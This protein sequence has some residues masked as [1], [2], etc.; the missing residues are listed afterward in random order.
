MFFGQT[1]FRDFCLTFPVFFFF[2]FTARKRSCG[3][4][5]F[6][7]LPTSHS[8]HRLGVYPSMYPG[9]GC[10]S[11]HVPGQGEGVDR[12]CVNGGVDGDKSTVWTGGVHPP[13]LPRWPFKCAVYNLLECIIVPVF[14]NVLFFKLKT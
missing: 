4:V 14:F 12:G 5:M 13:P 2:I 10:E 3:K 6:L 8:V 11:R 7:Q 1:K 9:R